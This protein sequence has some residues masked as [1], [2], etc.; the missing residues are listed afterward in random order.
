M[1]DKEVAAEVH[2]E[3]AALAESNSPGPVSVSWEIL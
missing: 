2:R 3:E 1:E